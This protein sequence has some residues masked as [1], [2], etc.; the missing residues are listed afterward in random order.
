M[1]H[2]QRNKDKDDKGFL[3]GNSANEKT[4]EQCLY[5]TERKEMSTQNYFI[6]EN[7]FQK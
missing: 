4:V 2:T 1:H 5:R 7:V 6:Q 3:I